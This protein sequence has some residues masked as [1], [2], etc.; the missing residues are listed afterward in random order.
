MSSVNEIKKEIEKIKHLYSLSRNENEKL[1]LKKK[2]DD[3]YESLKNVKDD[4]KNIVEKTNK[5]EQEQ[6]QEPKKD[7]NDINRGK[8]VEPGSNIPDN[9]SEEK[10]KREDNKKSNRN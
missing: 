4:N 2:M 8:V 5:A 9:K 6:H 1:D 3:L 10:E 7:N